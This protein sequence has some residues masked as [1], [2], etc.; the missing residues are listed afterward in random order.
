VGAVRLYLCFV[1]LVVHLEMLVLE[2]AGTSVHPAMTLG[3]GHFAVMYFYMIS[4]FVISTG[5]RWRYPPTTAGTIR[6]YQG[7]FVRVF[8]LYWPILLIVVALFDIPRAQFVE[9]S[10]A[11]QLCYLFLFGTDWRFA[12]ARDLES[13]IH[14][15]QPVWTL[16][17][18]LTFYVFA[19]FLL[20]S[21][22]W[23]V[24]V[25]IASLA[26]H[27]TV[28][29]LDGWS[30]WWSHWFLPS[31][32]CF[33]LFGHLARVTAERFSVLAHPIVG[34]ALLAVSISFTLQNPSW[35]SVGFWI[36][37]LCF[38]NSLPGLFAATKDNQ[39]LN[40]LGDLSFP[41]Y[42]VHYIFVLKLSET[43][44][45]S[46]AIAALGGSSLTAG[47]VFMLIVTAAVLVTAIA[48][49]HL[50][51]RPVGRL[52]RAGFDRLGRQAVAARVRPWHTWLRGARVANPMQPSTPL[53]PSIAE[54]R[55]NA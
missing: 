55:S 35:D 42:V 28:F 18:E 17:A 7:R 48:V 20:R 45:P 33:F 46:R 50:I 43:D 4:G 19:P 10:I 38:A 24:A 32:F 8:S 41:F 54:E 15:L 51:E 37:V 1:V 11:N 52:M 25:L 29:F 9:Q 30:W 47:V 3:I 49:H 23:W 34:F 5:L 16:G 36:A 21:T 39:V 13:A 12:L 22:K 14:Y 40:I 31:T 53:V 2:P 26:V 27:E 44:I 6:F